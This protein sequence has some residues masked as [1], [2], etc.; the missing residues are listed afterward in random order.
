MLGYRF[1]GVNPV[2]PTLIERMGFPVGNMKSEPQIL[3]RAVSIGYW[4]I[5]TYH[6]IWALD[7]G[8]K[9]RERCV[10]LR[11]C[12]LLKSPQEK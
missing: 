2:R 7:L 8:S 12:I 9:G 4:F 1:D 5:Y 3:N 6:L 10:P 11:G